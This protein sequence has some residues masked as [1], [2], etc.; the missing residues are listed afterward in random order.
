MNPDPHD[1]LKSLIESLQLI[2]QVLLT[3]PLAK[4]HGW[5]DVTAL[6][7]V[8]EEDS[9]LKIIVRK[10]KVWIAI[11]ESETAPTTEPEN[12]TAE[13]PA[14]TTEPEVSTKF[15]PPEADSGNKSG[16]ESAPP[17][18]TEVAESLLAMAD[19]IGGTIAHVNASPEVLAELTIAEL[20]AELAKVQSDLSAFR[21]HRER[22]LTAAKDVQECEDALENAK[23]KVT[24]CKAE[25]DEAHEDLAA[26]V[27]EE[28]GQQSLFNAPTAPATVPIGEPDIRLPS[29]AILND[30]IP[31]DRRTQA[32]RHGLTI[33]KLAAAMAGSKGLFESQ[34]K[35][36]VIP[37][38]AHGIP[39]LVE[40]WIN[41]TEGI[42]GSSGD[43][44][45]WRLIPLA[46]KEEW[47]SAHQETYGKPCN[48]LLDLNEADSNRLKAGGRFCGLVVRIANP[49][50]KRGAVNMVVSPDSVALIVTTEPVTNP[51]EDIA[52]K[53]AP[54]PTAALAEVAAVDEA[55]AN[56]GMGEHSSGA[57]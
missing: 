25:L 45:D 23:A 22:E 6:R 13:T 9:R 2:G 46:T 31:D 4:E 57:D 16:T 14:I 18:A 54:A 30:D 12:I 29:V 34:K 55:P 35:P 10:G 28:P 17:T 38:T 3:L 19:A 11:N 53:D 43:H 32:I 24:K 44:A 36:M 49:S 37:V 47:E 52:P 7:A 40:A 50:G 33:D 41:V 27:N 21:V 42:P 26:I 20:R 8:A 39:C 48:H 15:V 51:V 5:A 1:P 56:T